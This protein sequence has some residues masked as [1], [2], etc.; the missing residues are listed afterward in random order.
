MDVKSRLKQLMDER[1]WTIYKVAKEADIPWSTVRNMFKR[2]TEP[3]IAT[4][5]CICSGMGMTLPQFFDVDNQMGL[6]PEQRQLIQ[7]WNKLS[8]RERRLISE[9]VETLSEK[10]D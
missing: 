6:T 10:A 7:Q 5:E 9:L 2:N 4:L 1:G 3:S 8:I